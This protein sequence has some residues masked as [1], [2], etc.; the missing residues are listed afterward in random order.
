M[1][2]VCYCWTP[3][4]VDPETRLCVQMVYLG[5]DRKHQ[6]GSKEVRQGSKVAIIKG[7]CSAD[8]YCEQLGS[9]LLGNSED[10]T[11]RRCLSY[12]RTPGFVSFSLLHSLVENY[13]W[14]NKGTPA[15]MAC[16]APGT[17]GRS[18]GSWS[19]LEAHLLGVCGNDV[20]RVKGKGASGTCSPRG[21]YDSTCD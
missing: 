2:P 19:Q 12:L 20:P 16:P 18:S 15:L 10:S 17:R 3:P 7:D 8:S 14:E 5:G 6:L 9:V 11:E 1:L 13:S 4:G 21:K